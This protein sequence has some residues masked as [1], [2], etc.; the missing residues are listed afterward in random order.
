MKVGD[1]C[2]KALFSVAILA[3]WN[4]LY[5][6][7]ALDSVLR[8]DYP[9]FELI[10]SNDGSPDFNEDELRRYMNEHP[11]SHVVRTVIRNHP[12]NIGTVANAEW[13][14]RQ[15]QGDYF[16]LLA[17]DDAFFDSA[18]LTRYAE[19]FEHFGADVVCAGVWMCGQ[20]FCEP[21][22]RIPG[23]EEIQLLR[24]ADSER[25]FARLCWS[26]MIPTT[27]TCL[28]RTA[29]DRIG[30][31]DTGY[32][33]IEDATLFLRMAREGYRFFWLDA[34]AAYHRDGGVSHSNRMDESVRNYRLNEIRMFYREIRPYLER[35]DLYDRVR[36][37]RKAARVEFIYQNMFLYRFGHGTIKSH[38][39]M[40]HEF[41]QIIGRR[42]GKDTV[43]CFL[44]RAIWF[45][46][47][48][49][50]YRVLRKIYSGIRYLLRKL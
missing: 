30:G 28:R 4:Y 39:R 49:F 47:C 17:A 12:E 32:R 16:I 46:I 10:I 29:L 40:E 21:V 24:E 1:S 11:S 36:A 25:L 20:K 50:P 44:I 26:A 34:D 13:C 43:H 48:F 7:E 6:Y 22:R 38:I 8:Q 41:R 2:V 3:Y 5:L 23:G 19:A 15:A 31:Y 37:K 14:R 27:G 35:L 9:R 42:T 33:I 18:V 45:H